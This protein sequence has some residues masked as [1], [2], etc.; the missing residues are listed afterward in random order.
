MKQTPKASP[1][2]SKYTHRSRSG[3]AGFELTT[4]GRVASTVMERWLVYSLQETGRDQHGCSRSAAPRLP[5]GLGGDAGA[6][7]PQPPTTLLII[8]T[9]P[10]RK[11]RSVE[12]RAKKYIADSAAAVRVTP[13]SSDVG[14]E[15][16][17]RKSF[18]STAVTTIP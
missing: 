11:R 12:S 5:R 13:I 6:C 18:R 16:R 10:R 15:S 4:F 8:G 2:V 3:R 14:T 1:D 17:G 9:I 7:S